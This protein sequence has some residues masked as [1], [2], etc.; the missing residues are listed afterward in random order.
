MRIIL[1][2][3]LLLFSIC[4]QSQ[5]ARAYNLRIE[6]NALDSN[7]RKLL[8]VS[9]NM[10][11]SGVKGH[12]L[13]PVLFIDREKGVAHYFDDGKQMKWEGSDYYA[14]YDDTYWEGGGHWLGIYNDRLN[15]LP[16]TNIYHAR[17]LIWDVTLGR[18]IGN[19]NDTEWVAFYN[20][21][22]QSSNNG[23]GANYYVL[24]TPQTPTT[25]PCGV[26][27][28]SGKCSTCY[29][30]G[31]S[32]NHAAGIYAN[33]GACGGTGRCSTCRGLGYY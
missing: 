24:P 31:I 32:P 15:P 4:A 16:G 11:C 5:D 28:S 26:C 3:L 18:Y 17:I 25:N 6:H 27:S 29:G 22:A 8:K 7:G 30:R 13:K 23:G 9:F 19:L 14:T 10:K 21:G 20:T 2:T 12:T 1:S 33:C